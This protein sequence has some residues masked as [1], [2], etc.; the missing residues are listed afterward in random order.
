MEQ[1]KGRT[2]QAR[3]DEARQMDLGSGAARLVEMACSDDNPSVRVAALQRLLAVAGDAVVEVAA[4]DG[5]SWVREWAVRRVGAERYAEVL[6]R[7]AAH[8]GSWEVR[9][10]AVAKLPVAT[11]LDTIVE[12]A[13]RD[14]VRNPRVAALKRLIAEECTA[15]LVA[16]AE[17]ADCPGIR[18]AAVAR[19]DGA[20][21]AD[22]LA[23][24]LKHDGAP[25]VRAAAARQIDVWPGSEPLAETARKDSDAAVRAVAVDRLDRI[26]HGAELRDA[27]LVDPDPWVRERAVRRLSVQREAS[28]L[29]QRHGELSR[30]EWLGA[31]K[32]CVSADLTLFET[33]AKRDTA[34]RVRMAAV[35]ALDPEAHGAS[36]A[37]AAESDPSA[38]GREAALRRLT[39]AWT[40]GMV[41]MVRERAASDEF[42]VVRMAA[43]ERLLAANDEHG[44]RGLAETAA[45]PEVA[46]GAAAGLDLRRH[47][48]LLVV[49]AGSTEVGARHAEKR[50]FAAQHLDLVAHHEVLAKLAGDECPEVAAVAGARLEA[51][52]ASLAPAP[53]RPASGPS[54]G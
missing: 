11:H 24:I 1:E 53:R 36:I 26:V 17:G 4:S 12:V 46:V 9:A 35:E 14:P 19:L 13:S 28:M 42:N 15:G 40:V 48:D 20:Q 29:R 41:H 51:A 2:A 38:L 7:L 25:S 3:V 10:A 43:L 18:G 49:W 33:I 22:T 32:L 30:A 39:V 34:P 27:A 31:N 21:H 47:V 6:A 23:A 54:M 16:V 44:L 8:D 45:D 37:K 5:A 52:L 50:R